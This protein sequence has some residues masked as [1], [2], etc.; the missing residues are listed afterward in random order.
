MADR[1][2][3]QLAADAVVFQARKKIGTLNEKIA[4]QAAEIER[5]RNR[6][7]SLE[8]LDGERAKNLDRMQTALKRYVDR[9]AGIHDDECPED[10]TCQCVFVKETNDLCAMATF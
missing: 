4:M 8:R 9:Y 5:L 2:E 10:D 6:E 1:D 3:I 7:I